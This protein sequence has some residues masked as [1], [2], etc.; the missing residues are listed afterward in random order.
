MSQYMRLIDTSHLKWN[1]EL[2]LMHIFTV[3]LPVRTVEEVIVFSMKT[4]FSI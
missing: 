3:R 4:V 2:M 1:V